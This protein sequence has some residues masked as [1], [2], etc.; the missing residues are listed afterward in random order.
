[1]A[2]VIGVDLGAHS[3]KVAVM[4]GRL[5]RLALREYRIRRLVQGPE[6]PPDLEQRLEALGKILSEVG[7]VS[8]ATWAAAYPTEWVSLR[9]V[10]L[11]FQDR[12]QI[13]RTLS[14]ELE[15]HVP[16]DLD[17]FVLD[18]RVLENG[19]GLHARDR[20]EARVLCALADKT[21]L[22]GLVGGLESRGV[23]PR[24]LALDAELLAHF[25]PSH[26]VQVILD[27]GHTRTLVAFVADGELLSAR[28]IS[29]GGVDLT[30]ALVEAF[31]WSWEDAEG[32]KHIAHLD[33]G[34]A[35]AAVEWTEASEEDDE[36]TAPVS[37][38][39]ASESLNK[40][41]AKSIEPL[42]AGLKGS[43]LAFESQHGLDVEELIFTGG[44]SELGGLV[45]RISAE[46]SL[47]ARRVAATPPDPAPIVSRS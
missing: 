43:L 40:V 15:G 20:G 44:G 46:T 24:K 26:G 18:S 38:P 19:A 35:S 25:A 17:D 31:G 23:E 37:L 7:D 4:E 16:F 30:S 12:G 22:A 10:G 45:S 13:E 29:F 33:R 21:R 1:M 47:P 41:L 3:V 2:T 39:S 27:I 14:F 5:G 9:L 36:P 28:A 11:P 34:S 8:T 42:V 6:G 32:Q